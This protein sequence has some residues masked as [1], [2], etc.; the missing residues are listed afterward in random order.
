MAVTE[1]TEA[2]FALWKL[3]ATAIFILL[4]GF[5]VAAEF[6]LV[7]VR[8]SRI[9]SSA[10]NGS[11]S[12]R[13]VMRMITHLD[14]YLSA[15]QL[16][17]TV[18]S[19][20]LG[21]LAEPAVAS[22][23]ISGASSLGFDIA[24]NPWVHPVA[25]AVAL[26]FITMLHMT[27]GEQ[28]PKMLSIRKSEATILICA[29]PLYIFASIFKPMIWLINII[30]N[31]IARVGGGA[32]ASGHGQTYD[33]TEIRAILIS[34]AHAGHLSANQRQIGENVLGLTN[35]EV[36]HILVPR[37]ETA[38]LSTANS[39][40]KNL[41]IIQ[42][43][44]HSRFPL[45]DPDLDHVIGLIHSRSLLGRMLEGKT[46]DLLSMVRECPTVPDT[47]PL[48][49]LIR[50]LQEGKTHCATVVDEHGTT[51]GFA[52]LEDAIEEI[53]GPIYDEFD[54]ET[55]RIKRYSPTHVEMDGGVCT[56]EAS[57]ALGITLDD[58]TDTVGGLVV[59]KLGRLPTQGETLKLGPYEVTVI[60]ATRRRV[61]TLR[62]EK[63]GE[64]E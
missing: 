11:S 41:S 39:L 23:L 5:F 47:Q 53:V 57:D 56:P 32:P 15:C 43:A 44:G 33:L 4:N 35:I 55:A 17:I 14:H 28:T 9:E 31:F 34:A 36:R 10:I 13:L 58:E 45:A 1:T 24:T 21:W 22:L 27:V 16:G 18:A 6:A 54:K 46:P 52:F 7:K 49:R 29:Y 61:L 30:S 20:V 12:A 3:L 37:T 38:Y 63:K 62:F 19:L 59:A 50:N 51:V 26:A 48:S 25:L 40:E 2:T 60:K 42:S 8:P 64:L